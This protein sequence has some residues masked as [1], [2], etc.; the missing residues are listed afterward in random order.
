MAATPRGTLVIVGGGTRPDEVMDAYVHSAGGKSAVVCLIATATEDPDGAFTAL[1]PSI[2][3]LGGTLVNLSVRKREDATLPTTLEQAAK[4][5]GFWFSGGDQNRVGD[6][7]VGTALQKLLLKMYHSGATVGGSSAGAAI[8]SHVML[9]GD[10]LNGTS[11]I[12]EIGPGAY[13]TREGMGFLPENV[14]VDQHFLRRNREN[15]LISVL[16]DHPDHLGIGIDEE[17]AILVRDGHAK[18]IGNRKVMI[19]DPESMELQGDTFA[20]MQIHLLAKGQGINLRT[21][22]LD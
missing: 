2:D 12:E 16:M 3:R 19:F 13:K 15:R 14:I 10:D 11:S 1:K 22:K 6:A 7:I 8:M 5:T 21:R 9:T 20:G 17:T 4:C 18:V